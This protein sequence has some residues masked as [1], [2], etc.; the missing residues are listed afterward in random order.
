MNFKESVEAVKKS[1][2]EAI[3]ETGLEAWG[4]DFDEWGRSSMALSIPKELEELADKLERCLLKEG[5]VLRNLTY[6]WSMDSKWTVGKNN[7]RISMTVEPRAD[8]QSL[9]SPS[10][11]LGS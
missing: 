1:L 2:N 4:I 8:E 9:N 3:K 6:S 10:V 11:S 7:A 5:I